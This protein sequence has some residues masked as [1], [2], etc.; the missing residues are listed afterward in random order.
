M[1]RALN[2]RDYVT[3]LNTIL[4]SPTQCHIFS[5]ALPLNETKYFCS[6]GN[7]LGLYLYLYI[8]II[9]IN[10][11]ADDLIFIGIIYF[12][13]SSS[14]LFIVVVKTKIKQIFLQFI[15][16][17]TKDLNTFCACVCVCV[18]IICNFL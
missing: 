3:N 16:L 17:K 1:W 14:Y 12:P 5:I 10:K 4:P 6:R 18:S 2:A 11:Y 15:Q 13:F 9:K 8:Y 7:V